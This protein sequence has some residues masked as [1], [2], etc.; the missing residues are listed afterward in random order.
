MNTYH[1][2]NPQRSGTGITYQIFTI[3][4]I[5]HDD[6]FAM[7]VTS[8]SFLNLQRIAYSQISLSDFFG[9]LP[10]FAGYQHLMDVEDTPINMS[11]TL[12]DGVG[13]SNGEYYIGEASSNQNVVHIP[14]IAKLA[15]NP[16]PGQTIS[17]TSK[18]Y[19]SINKSY[20]FD[21]HWTYKTIMKLDQWGA[22]SDVWR[23]GLKEYNPS[24]PSAPGCVYNYCFMRNV[25]LIDLWYG[26]MQPDGS[27]VGY[28]YYA[29]DYQVL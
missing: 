29:V 27:I 12:V 22:F 8:R 28:E 5:W 11:G 25:G 9:Y 17:P 3:T 18:I 1:P 4:G 20:L 24:N 2:Y 16:Y 15:F 26:Q 10:L 6:T 14:F 7:D 21:F 13:Y 19:N 23:T